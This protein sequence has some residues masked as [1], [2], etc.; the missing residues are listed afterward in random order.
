MKTEG[1]IVRSWLCII[2]IMLGTAQTMQ[3]VITWPT[4]GTTPDVLNED[5]ILDGAFSPITISGNAPLCNAATIATT[6]GNN[7]T[8]SIV[9]DN[10]VLQG[11]TTAQTILRLKPAL[12]TTITFDLT[13]P[14]SLT[15][16]GSVEPEL[17]PLLILHEGQGTVQFNMRGGNTLVLTNNAGANGPVLFYVLA[18]T[19]ATPLLSFVRDD[20]SNPAYY[21][22][23]TVIEIGPQSLLSF[24]STDGL[25]NLSTATMTFN[26]TNA[27]PNTGRMVLQIDDTGAFTMAAQQAVLDIGAG[28]YCAVNRNIPAGGIL[29]INVT[30][31][32]LFGASS[33]GL[34]IANY[35]ATYAE[36]LVDPYGD[37]GAASDPIFYSGS[38]DGLRYGVTLGANA[39][40]NINNLAY[41]DYVGLS[42]NIC[43]TP[44]SIPGVINSG[45]DLGC[46]CGL[47]E[48]NVLKL[49]NYSAFTVDGWLNPASRPAQIVFGI[50]QSGIYF[51]SGVDV[52]GVVENPTFINSHV[53]TIVPSQMTPGAGEYVFDVEGLLNIFGSN[54]GITG[55]STVLVSRLEI[56]SWEVVPDGGPLFPVEGLTPPT[57]DIFL[58]RDFA[59]DTITG[60]LY[61]YNSAAW[62]IN[63]TVNIYN[64]AIAHTDELHTVIQNNDILSEPTYVGG[65]A[66]WLSS[67][68]NQMPP[69]PR[70]SLELIGSVIQV[71]TSIALTGLDIGIPTALD[72]TS[73]YPNDS[74]FTF[75]SNGYI[76][77]QGTGRSMILGTLIGS[78][79]CDGC[80]VISDDA[81]INIF[82]TANYTTVI[83][84]AIQ[85]LF[86]LSSQNNSFVDNLITTFIDSQ[87]SVEPI[88]L[89]HN[90][91]ISIG[92]NASST[93]FA[94]DTLDI[95][96]ISGDFFHIGTRGG[97]LG[98]PSTSSVTGQGGI[99]VDLNGVFTIL[100]NYVASLD[101]MVTKSQ[102][103]IVNL[104]P[105][106]VFFS[107]QVGVTDWELN[108]TDSNNNVII[109][110]GEYYSD[111]TLNWL[112]VT[113]NEGFLPYLIGNIN[114]CDC[115][116]VVAA[117]LE[118]IPVIQ[119]QVDQFLVENSR[120][121]DPATFWISGGWVREIVW[122]FDC[123]PGEA[124]VAVVV[125]DGNGR[126]GL[127]NAHRNA[128]STFAQTVLGA[129]G[130]NIIANGDCQIV[131][132]TDVIVNNICALIQGPGFAEGN[133]V[134][135]IADTP[136]T[137][138]VTQNGILDFSNFTTP[139]IIR[140][141]GNIRVLFEPGSRLILGAADVEFTDVAV[142][143]IESAYE[144]QLRIAALDSFFGVIDNDVNPL[145][146]VPYTDPNNDYSPLTNYGSGLDNTDPYR[147]RI[148]GEGTLRFT[149]AASLLALTNG[150]IGIET[151]N[152]TLANGTV[153]V[154]DTTDVTIELV[155][156]GQFNLG[157]G[158]NTFGGV[159]QVGDVLP[160][161]GHDVNFTLT[162]NGADA[163]F[164]TGAGSFFGIGAGVVRPNQGQS[165]GTLPDVQ[166]NVLA[167]VLNDVNIV[168]FNFLAGSFNHNRTVT[169]DDPASHSIVFGPVNEF[170]VN[171]TNEDT[172]EGF[173]IADF[174]CA[175]GGNIFYMVPGTDDD[176][177]LGALRLICRTD[178]NVINA[179]YT[180]SSTGTTALDRLFDGILAST[181][182]LATFEDLS[183]TSQNIFL[184]LKASEATNAFG[185]SFGK[186]TAAPA[187]IETFR[188]ELTLGIFGYVDRSMIG[189]YTFADLLDIN[190]GSEAE[191]RGYAFGLGAATIKV[192]T[193]LAAPGPVIVAGNIPS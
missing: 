113:K 129:N 131:L 4:A 12:N 82:Q 16:E 95:F 159:L 105:A 182:M 151:L 170:N 53:F 56:L 62:L 23:Q 140:F 135:F 30:N 9:H 133:I 29:S 72:G 142:M 81:H 11:N 134:E 6:T 186:A 8:V 42:N 126:L 136:Y 152:E 193:A 89:G 168:T 24:A 34:I 96:A 150:V 60:E 185:R 189:R 49:R 54:T 164:N 160:F 94:N 179:P 103:G 175:G 139:G 153:C 192:D 176:D 97:S 66:W 20:V 37:L 68:R 86:L 47:S 83:T 162:L 148:M 154:I 88:Y 36:Y 130:I 137:L 79:A 70:P 111:Y 28:D 180:G 63:N 115:P 25:V 110:T 15:F 58:G 146:S 120:V 172:I 177:N 169:S 59:V 167:D 127:N 44:S 109:P 144:L 27:L 166:S 51:R 119:G 161:E 71:Q 48:S 67:L 191:R 84:A 39:S 112:T 64:T 22:L 102:N 85:E 114:V 123:I 163:V 2:G 145:V 10:V 14:Y 50:S 75:Y 107:D 124:P 181:P 76:V 43:P 77:D 33:A 165:N 91:N 3:A 100:P 118:N 38:F 155:E 21:D 132:N 52:D 26:P 1:R 13:G 184:D 147:V 46:A 35:N 188:Q 156:G 73:V 18:Q 87:T 74:A 149:D 141:G 104:P 128:D 106:Q 101:V 69:V 117:N 98:V 31:S 122:I 78:Q 65:E 17:F 45:S 55:N 32:N 121:G 57:P 19:A 7:I 93:G 125:M 40:L 92:T 138:H 173:N 108:L 143:E 99:F 80:T 178:D 5:L 174:L 187:S 171:Y 41:L 183:D 158:N 190:G 116:P 157:T 90:S 61:Q